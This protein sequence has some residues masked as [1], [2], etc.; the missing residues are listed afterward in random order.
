MRRSAFAYETREHL[1]HASRSDAPC[2]IDGKTLLRKFVRDRQTFYLPTI[3]TRI[4]DKIVAPDLIG[5]ARRQ[6]SWPRV[7]N[8]LSRPLAWYLQSCR[9]PK[10]IRPADAHSMAVTSEEYPNAT[11]AVARILPR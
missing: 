2:H 1:D 5:K 6:R 10:P 9:P 11:V 7:R 3:R 4:E 8:P